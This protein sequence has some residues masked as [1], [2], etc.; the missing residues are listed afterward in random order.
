VKRKA[1]TVIPVII[2]EA[3]IRKEAPIFG[4]LLAPLLF[5]ILLELAPVAPLARVTVIEDVPAL[6]VLGVLRVL[7]SP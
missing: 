1:T 3:V 5:G 2:V 6:A 4:V 7:G